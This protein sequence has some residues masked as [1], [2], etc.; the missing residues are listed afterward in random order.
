MKVGEEEI[1]EMSVIVQF[2]DLTIS[3]LLFEEPKIRMYKAVLPVLPL[4]M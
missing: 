4:G 1:L 2:E 3:R